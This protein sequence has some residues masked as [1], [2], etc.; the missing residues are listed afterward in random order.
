V[1]V[2]QSFQ[3]FEIAIGNFDD[4]I[5]VATFRQYSDCCIASND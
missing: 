1:C 3:C 5:R 4:L 2:G